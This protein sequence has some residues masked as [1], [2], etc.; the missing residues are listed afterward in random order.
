MLYGGWSRTQCC[1]Q[2]WTLKGM[3]TLERALLSTLHFNAHE[4]LS[5]D[6]QAGWP[7]F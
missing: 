7:L 6:P 1:A 5:V 3:T 4:G 2:R